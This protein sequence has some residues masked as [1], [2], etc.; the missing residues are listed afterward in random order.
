MA[1]GVFRV[2]MSIVCI[3]VCVA[4][5]LDGSNIVAGVICGPVGV[6][7]IGL[8]KIIVVVADKGFVVPMLVIFVVVLV[9][10]RSLVQGVGIGC[11]GNIG[12]GEAGESIGIDGI[13]VEEGFVVVTVVFRVI[14]RMIGVSLDN[15]ETSV[16][17]ERLAIVEG[18]RFNA[19][20]GGVS[21]R[22]KGPIVAGIASAGGQGEEIVRSLSVFDRHQGNGAKGTG[23]GRVSRLSILKH[24]DIRTELE[25]QGV[26]VG[27]RRSSH[28]GSGAQRVRGAAV[29][30]KHTTEAAND[31]VDHVTYHQFWH[32]FFEN[33][34]MNRGTEALL[35][36]TDGLLDL[37]DMAVSGHDFHHH[38]EDVGADILKFGVGVDIANGE[39][40][41]W[42]KATAV[43]TNALDKE[44]VG[45]QGHVLMVREHGRRDGN[46]LESRSAARGGASHLTFKDRYVR[47]IDEECFVSVVLGDQAVPDE[48]ISENGLE[49]RHWGVL[50]CSDRSH[51]LRRRLPPA[52]L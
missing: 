12:N 15:E 47:T 35:G 27:Q 51:A 22:K 28:D 40:T 36:R 33:E 14:N 52:G 25:A 4:C 43:E 8:I 46:S 7:G 18:K 39:T 34:A 6:V 44:E 5:P 50:I 13:E 9:G 2:A 37:A 42:F 41:V 29:A 19:S 10:M 21:E 24:L 30:G 23:T 16:L 11:W 48:L 20:D 26:V 32:T 49:L 45:A 17:N 3:L 38:G 31:D 1:L